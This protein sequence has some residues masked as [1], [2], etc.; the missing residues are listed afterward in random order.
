MVREFYFKGK[1]LDELKGM[2]VDDFAKICRARERRS[3]KRGLTE[4]QKKLLKRIEKNPGKFNKTRERDMI[5]VPQMLGRKIGV[6]SG[7]E[8]VE[9]VIRPDMLG[10][11]LGEFV[12]TRRVVKHS[13]P[14]FGATRSSKYVPLK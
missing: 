6:Y 11:R 14:G 4:V 10:H 7:K 1:K 8:Y 3:F 13:A 9:L 5:I 12:L 2:P